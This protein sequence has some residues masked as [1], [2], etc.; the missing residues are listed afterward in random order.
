MEKLLKRPALVVG[1]I[2]VITVFFCLQLPRARLDNN[3]I[4]FLP[5]GNQAK[6][7]SEYIDETFGGQVMILAGLERPY[8]TVFE[9]DFLKRIRDFSQ[10]VE[11]IDYI[12]SVNSIMSTRYITGDGDSIVV[13]DL[14]PDNF[15]GTDE[16]IIELRRRIASWDLFRGSLV[17]DDLSSTQ[18]LITLDSLTADFTRPE[19]TRSI[20]EIRKAAGRIFAGEAEVYF[21]GQPVINA[22]INKSIIEDNLL[23]IPL[24][25]IVVLAMLFFSFRRFTFVILPFLTVI[26]AVVW[27]VGL[28]ALLGIKLSVITTILPVILVAVGSAYGIHIV[29]HYIEDTRGNTFN[30]TQHRELVL[31]LVKKLIKPVFLAALTTLA[32]FVSFC[33]TPIVPMREFGFCA[34][35]GV[36]AAFAVA[37]LFIPS[38]FLLRGPRILNE[39]RKEQTSGGSFSNTVAG[40]FT[41]IAEK[42]ALVLVCAALAALISLYGLSKVI[43]D[44]AVVEFFQ[45]ETDISRSDRF[46]REHFGGSKDLNLVVTADTTEELLH[47]EVLQAVD[48]LSAYLTAYVPAVG[49]VVGFT[50]IIKR[51]NQVFNAGESPEGL[52]SVKSYN[53]ADSFGFNDADDF[54][55]GY[56]DFNDDNFAEIQQQENNFNITQYNTADLLRFLDNAAGK[57]PD[58]SGSDLVRELKR[59]TNYEGMAYYEI[60]S[61]PQRY[62]KETYEELERLIAN[63][64]V[65][66]AG[67]DDSGYSNDPLEPTAIKTMIQL[68]TTGSKDSREVIDI[69][70]EYIAVNFPKNVNVIIG[71]GI[72]Y[73]MAITDLIFNSQIIS[74]FISVLIVFLIMAFSNKS[75]IAGVIGAVPL[76]LAILCNFAVMGFTG[77]KLNLGTALISSLAVGIG[78][79]YTIHFIEFFK[80]EYQSGGQDFLRRTFIGCGKAIMINALSVGAGFGVLAFSRFRIIAE[81]GAL[82]ALSMLITAFVSLTVIPALLMVIKPKFIYLK[83]RS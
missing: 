63:Y 66:L 13:S 61:N 23:L 68:R 81:L 6:L 3:N 55:F 29:T 79:D 57:S 47:P 26:I 69:V 74:I 12:K 21:T 4:R 67:D 17:S 83:D 77:I 75:L 33:F 14:V 1:V 73:E 48:N 64:L 20:E 37:V 30:I 54:G 25:V 49:K 10:A 50:D 11:S 80:R 51:I 52:R 40:I 34:G 82:I 76:T 35:V 38:M 70:K 43:V 65:L 42:K 39:R 41:G 27:T 59:L 8:R 62:G 71:G 36:L 56:F 28:A 9:K 18:I 31:G 22:I 16:E 44:N 15:S 24:V 5:A 7:I 2:I 60:P 19:V 45:N 46:I 72:T 78:I 53:T 32:G 58:L